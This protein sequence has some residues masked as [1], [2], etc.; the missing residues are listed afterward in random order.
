MNQN[1]IIAFHTF[2]EQILGAMWENC[3][4]STHLYH[5]EHYIGG[6]AGDERKFFICDGD[7]VA[8]LVRMYDI[9][10]GEA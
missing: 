4:E 5:N 9:Y 7:Y 3:D 1:E 10:T 8:K 6:W 2:A